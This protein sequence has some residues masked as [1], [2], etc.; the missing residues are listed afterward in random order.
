MIDIKIEIHTI[1]RKKIIFITSPR[2]GDTIST[3]LKYIDEHAE[4]LSNRIKDSWN[5]YYTKSLSYQTKDDFFGDYYWRKKNPHFMSLSIDEIKK[6]HSIYLNQTEMFSKN[7][8]R[9]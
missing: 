9:Y 1:K 7:M 6:I 5:K 2:T 8:F 4:I 3:E